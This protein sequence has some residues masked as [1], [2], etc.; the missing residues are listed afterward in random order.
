[1]KFWIKLLLIWLLVHFFCLNIITFSFGFESKLISS[2]KEI[3]IFVF[4]LFWIIVLLKN[5]KLSKIYENKTI[6]F[7]EI[8][9]LLLILLSFLI[10]FFIKDIELYRYILTF[11]YDFFGFVI[12]FLFYNI[13]NNIDFIKADFVKK[14][15]Y[16]YWKL[17]KIS[18]ILALFWYVIIAIKPWI[19]DIFWYNPDIHEWVVG[20]KPPAVYLTQKNHWLARNQFLF[21][22]PINYGFWLIAFWPLFY[23]L[24][25][26][27]RA[28]KKTYFRRITYFLNIISTFSRAAWW[29]WIFEIIILWLFEYRKNIK[30]FL[31]KVILPLFLLLGI[32]SIIAYEHIIL[33]YFSNSWHIQLFQKWLMMFTENPM[34]WKWAWYVGPASFWGWGIEFNPENQFLQILIE[35]W[36]ILFLI[37]F[38]I[39]L[40]LNFFW[41]YSFI[42]SDKKDKK[43]F[44]ILILLAFSVWMIWLSI[45]WMVLHSFVDRMIVYPLMLL[46]WLS[47]WIYLKEKN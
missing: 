31:K 13:A 39:Y 46:Y 26:R 1:M 5:K 17:I 11:K 4:F 35:F 42:K 29:A 41:I 36:I 7:L 15:L 3:L 14:L 47:L 10:N 38:I 12:F 40:F 21:E 44:W 2:W 37:W 25:L 16:F 22:R 19:I 28:F 24:F 34:L 43:N 27:R 32:I 23:I 8:S 6:F 20:E 30:W 45:E 9:F 33:R 18:L